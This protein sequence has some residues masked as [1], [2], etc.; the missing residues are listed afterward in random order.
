ME[1]WI[2][3]NIPLWGLSTKGFLCFVRGIR[4]NGIGGIRDRLI[5][6]YAPFLCFSALSIFPIGQ[7]KISLGPGSPQAGL[8][9]AGGFAP[10]LLSALP[11]RHPGQQVPPASSLRGKCPGQALFQTRPPAVFLQEVPYFYGRVFF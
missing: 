5:A 7:K 10:E 9:Q 8:M 3:H 2:E 4:E 6:I 11:C 1:P